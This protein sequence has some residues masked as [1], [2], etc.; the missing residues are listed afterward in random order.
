MKKY[1]TITLVLCLTLLVGMLAGCGSHKKKE[2][3][4]ES[5][6]T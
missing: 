1:K 5:T 6:S 3:S 4:E 2:K